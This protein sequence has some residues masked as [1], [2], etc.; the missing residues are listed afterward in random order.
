MK[1]EELLNHLKE[2]KLHQNQLLKSTMLI[3]CQ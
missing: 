1:I 2:Y 3:M